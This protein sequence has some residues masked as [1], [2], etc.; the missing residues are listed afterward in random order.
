V[1]FTR[2]VTA[3]LFRAMAA[4]PMGR[5]IPATANLASL[6]E[7][8]SARTGTGGPVTGPAAG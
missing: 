5:S 6:H 2:R 4:G 1:S 7:N 3:N 8:P